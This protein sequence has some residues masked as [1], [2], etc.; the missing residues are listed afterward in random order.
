MGLAQV[1]PEVAPSKTALVR[2]VEVA[3]VAL[4][5]EEVEE[6]VRVLKVERVWRELQ[7]PQATPPVVAR[8]NHTSTPG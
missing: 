5:E 3:Q 7:E 2:A 4:V 8:A 1:A 6:E